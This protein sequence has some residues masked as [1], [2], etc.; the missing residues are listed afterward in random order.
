MLISLAAE[1]VV[2]MQELSLLDEDLAHPGWR[3][4]PGTSMILCS[5]TNAVNENRYQQFLALA[6]SRRCS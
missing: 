6:N 2:R 4:L 5:S 3:R 1:I